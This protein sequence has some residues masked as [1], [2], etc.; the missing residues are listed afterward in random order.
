MNAQGNASAS[1]VIAGLQ[2]TIGHAGQYGIR[3]V[4]L[5]LGGTPV[6]DYAHDPVAVTPAL[7][8]WGGDPVFTVGFEGWLLITSRP[9]FVLSS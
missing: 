4:N 5:S 9:V 2:W 8:I 7:S 6:T 3:V 1:S